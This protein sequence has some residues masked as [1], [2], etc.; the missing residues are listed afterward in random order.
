MPGLVIARAMSSCMPAALTGPT[1]DQ[2]LPL[3]P[4]RLS[5]QSP[6][7]RLSLHGLQCTV[8]A[9]VM[10]TN[11]HNTKENLRAHDREALK[12]LMDAIESL[13][14]GI[15]QL[16]RVELQLVLPS[17]WKV[18]FCEYDNA[19]SSGTV[20]VTLVDFSTPALP[21][22]K[23]VFFSTHGLL[24]NF[25]RVRELFPLEAEIRRKMVAIGAMPP[26]MKFDDEADDKDNDWIVDKT[27]D[28]PLSTVGVGIVLT[29]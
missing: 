12:R 25:R 18:T 10:L 6:V 26:N 15:L 29:H 1:N 4:L 23:P 28:V 14:K 3:A 16:V 2:A 24:L 5:T 21:P 9:N 17:D 13:R 8:Y 27:T 20:G 7:P 11:D 19:C 22:G